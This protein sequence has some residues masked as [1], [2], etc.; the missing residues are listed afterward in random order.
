M[1]KCMYKLLTLLRITSLDHKFSKRKQVKPIQLHMLVK[2][3]KSYVQK[4]LQCQ[5]SHL[6][7]K[8]FSK[9][10]KFYS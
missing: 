9:E 1:I 10:N 8:N 3:L 5:E 4:F 2:V 6:Q 7:S